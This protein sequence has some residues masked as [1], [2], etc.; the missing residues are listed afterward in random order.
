MNC[1]YSYYDITILN[2]PSG[3]GGDDAQ[4][5]LSVGCYRSHFIY[6]E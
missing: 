5:L 3:V 1:P 4:K 6:L 2:S